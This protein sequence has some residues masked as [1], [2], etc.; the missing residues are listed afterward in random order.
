MAIE[1]SVLSKTRR[2]KDDVY[3]TFGTRQN[4]VQL[5]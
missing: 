2:Q 5:K 4:L 3:D 1:L